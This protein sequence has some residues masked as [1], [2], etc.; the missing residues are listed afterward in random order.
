MK[1]DY[2]ITALHYMWTNVKISGAAFCVRCIFLLDEAA[3][4]QTNFSIS[5]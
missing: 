5:V 2:T 1:K 3:M 4:R